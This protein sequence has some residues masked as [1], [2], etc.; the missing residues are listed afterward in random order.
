MRTSSVSIGRELETQ[1]AEHSVTALI[2]KGDYLHLHDKSLRYFILTLW[3]EQGNVI[4][5][6]MDEN[7]FSSVIANDE[8]SLTNAMFQ[9][10]I[11]CSD[12]LN[13]GSMSTRFTFC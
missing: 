1:I 13:S 6:I 2:N 10:L 7:G 8:S 9:E 3:Y 11:N 12:V 4:K 5:T